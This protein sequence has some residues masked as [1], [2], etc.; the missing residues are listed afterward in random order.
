MQCVP[1]L[2]RT[3]LFADFVDKFPTK[4]YTI[5]VTQLNRTSFWGNVMPWHNVFLSIQFL[6]K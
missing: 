3:F 2:G 1:S 6:Q 5:I 4:W